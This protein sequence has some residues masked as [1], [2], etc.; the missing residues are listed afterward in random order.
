[1]IRSLSTPVRTSPISYALSSGSATRY[2]DPVRVRDRDDAGASDYT[3]HR[4]FF[5]VTWGV[6]G[7]ASRSDDTLRAR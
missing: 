6:T 7:W 3:T 4:S 2:S 5:G 1:M